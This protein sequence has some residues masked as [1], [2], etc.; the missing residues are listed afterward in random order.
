MIWRLQTVLVRIDFIRHRNHLK[1][2]MHWRKVGLRLPRVRESE[3]QISHTSP[4]TLTYREIRRD[5][6]RREA[7]HN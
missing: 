5:H 4:L 3:Q 6:T 1:K 2:P 7:V